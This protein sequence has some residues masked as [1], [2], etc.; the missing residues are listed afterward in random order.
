M[1][2]VYSTFSRRGLSIKLYV[3][4]AGEGPR[5]KSTEK[6]WIFP[7]FYEIMR[8]DYMERPLPARLVHYLSLKGIH[9]STDM[10]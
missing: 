5:G 2:H 9:I 4:V 1:Y 3:T 8:W 7:G 10:R 6:N